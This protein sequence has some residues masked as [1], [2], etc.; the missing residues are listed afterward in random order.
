MGLAVVPVAERNI[1]NP[2]SWRFDTES[3]F[4]AHA[5]G[6][7]RCHVWLLGTGEYFG[8]F[9]GAEPNC[10]IWA[11]GANPCETWPTAVSLYNM[12]EPEPEP[13]QGVLNA[14]GVHIELLDDR[15]VVRGEKGTHEFACTKCARYLA[16]SLSPDRTVLALARDEPTTLELRDLDTGTELDHI[17]MR[18]PLDASI[19]SLQL[20]WGINGLVAVVSRELP[21]GC[22][23]QQQT[24]PCAWKD[25]NHAIAP[26]VEI[27]HWRELDEAPEVAIVDWSGFDGLDI[28]SPARVNQ[29]V[30][31]PSQRWLFATAATTRGTQETS[32]VMLWEH[33]M[34]TEPSGLAEAR[35]LSPDEE[36]VRKVAWVGGHPPVI[37][38]TIHS[39]E[40]GR[41]EWEWTVAALGATPLG[42]EEAR[43]LAVFEYAP[44]ALELEFV[45]VSESGARPQWRACWDADDEDVPDLRYVVRES[46]T[47]TVSDGPDCL[48]SAPFVGGCKA[49]AQLATGE[50]LL[51]CAEQWR[52]WRA[53]DQSSLVLL[54]SELEQVAIG[55]AGFGLQADGELVVFDNHGAERARVSSARVVPLTHGAQNDR[56]L[57]AGSTGASL[58]DLASG[59]IVSTVPAAWASVAAMASSAPLLA[60]TDGDEIAVFDLK[61]EQMVARWAAPETRKLAWRR[62]AAVLFSSSN[63]AWPESAWAPSTGSRLVEFECIDRHMHESFAPTWEWAIGQDGSITRQ[64]DCTTIESRG[65]SLLTNHGHLVGSPADFDDRR[66]RI[67]GHPELGVWPLETFADFIQTSKLTEDFFSA[68]P[69]PAQLVDESWLASLYARRPFVEE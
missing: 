37:A 5:D 62:D 9:G 7:S 16:A 68:E 23:D 31:D 46:A 15:V 41:D 40:V 47:K 11:T 19:E 30:V 1:D 32:L 50:I 49:H 3:Q 65:Q 10:P 56:V 60:V 6:L 22:F 28:D 13:V 42:F 29:I 63:P 44:D 45:A 54:E 58:V 59:E 2:A 20:W 27:W 18:G 43:E 12:F 55:V 14:D 33:A 52:W 21:E 26:S 34:T 38:T 35:E 57:V 25:L 48:R 64:L 4:V 36:E 39:Y 53:D 24:T 67:I 69:L 51:R 66:I 17:Q 8:C 61:Q